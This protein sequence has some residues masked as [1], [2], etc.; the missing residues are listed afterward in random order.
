VSVHQTDQLTAGVTGRTKNCDR[1]S[2]DVS[3]RERGIYAYALCN[4]KCSG[5]APVWGPGVPR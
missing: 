2:H 4:A 5:G 3:S 1:S